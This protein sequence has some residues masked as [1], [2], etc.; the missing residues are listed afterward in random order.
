MIALVPNK[1]APHDQ[2]PID[3][4]NPARCGPELRTLQRPLAAAAEGGHP[5]YPHRP[6]PFWT[7]MAV[8]FVVLAMTGARITSTLLISPDSFRAI[9]PGGLIVA[10]W[11]MVSM[12]AVVLIGLPIRL[13]PKVRRW[14]IENGEIGVSG[15]ILGCVAI[16]ASYIRGHAKEGTAHG[17]EHTAWIPDFPC[18]LAGWFAM[19]FFLTHVWFPLRWRRARPA[20]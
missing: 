6:Y 11:T 2:P 3:P 15:I 5:I 12:A 17:M 14:W 20:E 4:A 19:S 7:Q 16:V 9:L 10:A 13:I 1:S 18:L 8:A